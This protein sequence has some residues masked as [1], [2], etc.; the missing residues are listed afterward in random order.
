VGCARVRT[1]LTLSCSSTLAQ[2]KPPLF[3]LKLLFLQ[4]QP[5]CSQLQILYGAQGVLLVLR[6]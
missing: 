1:L 5:F 4:L 6:G 3:Q 2:L